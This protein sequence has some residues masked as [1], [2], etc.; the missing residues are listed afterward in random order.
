MGMIDT[1]KDAVRLVQKV[2]NIELYQTIL[3]LQRDAMNL[4][5]EK[6]ALAEEIRGLRDQVRELQSKL[7]FSAKLIRRND[8]YFSEAD[9][10]PYC[11]QCWEVNRTPVHLAR[12]HPQMGG[13]IYCR[14]AKR[15]S[16]TQIRTLPDARRAAAARETPTAPQP[17][18]APTAGCCCVAQWNAPRPHT[19]AV[20]STPT[21]RRRGKQRRSISSASASFACANVGTSTASLPM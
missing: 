5:A 8:V 4:V 19:S 13:G 12:H 10:E 3:Q 9:P 14:T 11:P 15:T 16:R 17:R 7:A 1:L 21:M 18:A 20:L 2:D 6:H